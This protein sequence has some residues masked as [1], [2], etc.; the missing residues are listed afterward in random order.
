MSGTQSSSALTNPVG[1]DVCSAA[2]VAGCSC[3]IAAIGNT[4]APKAATTKMRNLIHKLYRFKSPESRELPADYSTTL[5]PAVAVVTKL[6][7][8]LPNRAA[9]FSASDAVS[10]STLLGCTSAT[11]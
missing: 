2:V 6:A 4:D 5:A 3:A 10:P 11:M 7:G 8:D 9:Y 1:G